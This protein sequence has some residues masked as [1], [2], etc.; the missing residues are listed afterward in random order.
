MSQKE[1]IRF[2]NV[3]KIFDTNYALKEINLTIN[4]GEFVVFLGESGSGKTTLLRLI[5][6]LIEPD[7]GT[8]KIKGQ[9]LQNINPMPLRRK[10]GYVIQ[11]TGLFPHLTIRDNITYVLSLEKKSEQE[12]NHIAEELIS[13]IGLNSSYLDRYPNELSGGEAQRVGVARGFAN[14]PEIILM[15]EPFGAVDDINRRKLQKELKTLNQTL[16]KTIVFVTHDIQEAFY[17]GDQI[18]ILRE[19][20]LIQKGNVTQ[21]INQPANKYV[22]DFIGINGYISQ[23]EPEQIKAAYKIAQNQ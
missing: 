21:L 20:R 14:D 13:L 15:D 22:S 19:G 5:N 10:M 11:Q 18:C 16:K 2:E 7:A 23:L 17:L 6:R 3:S 12:K 8:I 4:Q 9:N 1:L